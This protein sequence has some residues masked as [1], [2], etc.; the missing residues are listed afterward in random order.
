MDETGNRLCRSLSKIV[1]YPLTLY[2][3]SGTQWLKVNRQGVFNIRYIFYDAK[4][5][6]VAWMKTKGLFSRKYELRI[7][8][9]QPDFR[10]NIIS[11]AT[12]MVLFDIADA[13]AAAVAA[14]F[15]SAA[16]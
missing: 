9:L 16:R 5:K 3:E 15:A 12:A 13:A 11:I 14:S 4:G 6:E 1:K 2:T 7:S 10:N 8:Q